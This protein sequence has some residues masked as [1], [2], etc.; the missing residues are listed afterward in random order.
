MRLLLM[1]L[2]AGLAAALPT[3]YD[4]A[5]NEVGTSEVFQQTRQEAS[6]SVQETSYFYSNEGESIIEITVAEAP[7]YN[8]VCMPS[9]ELVESAQVIVQETVDEEEA[10]VSAAAGSAAAS[11]A[12]SEGAAASAAAGESAAA[13]AAAAESAAASAAASEGAATSAAAGEAAAASAAAAESAAASA[14][15]A[16]DAAAAS[17]AASGG[18]AASAAAGEAAAA[19]AAAAESAAASAAAAE[20]AAASAAAGDAA[21]ASA[22]A[23]ESAAASAAAAEDAAASAAA[24]EGAATSAAAGGAA[25]ASAAAAESAAASAAAGEAAA[26]SAA[27]AESAAASAAAAEGAA[28]SAAAGESAAASAAAAEGAASS[29]AAGESAAAAAAAA[30]SA[31][32]AAAAAEGAAASAAAGEGAA[33]SSAAGEGA[34]ASAAAG[35]KTETSAAI[36]V[37]EYVGPDHLEACTCVPF[38]LCKDENIISDGAGQIDIRFGAGAGPS[39]TKCRHF[40]SVCCLHPELRPVPEIVA[41]LTA[42]P[43]YPS[44]GRRN[45]EGIGFAI[46]GFKDSESQF[47]EFPHMAIIMEEEYI[48]GE[49][50]HRYVC[51]GSLVTTNIILTAGH[52]VAGKDAS[53]LLVRLGDWNTK[54]L[55]E[56]L[57]HQEYRVTRSVVHER[58]NKRTLFNTVALLFLESEVELQPHIDTIC[59]PSL[60]DVS[61]GVPFYDSAHCVATG[62][63]RDQFEGGQYQNIM[64]QVDLSE[65][66][67]DDCQD[68]LRRTRLG[69][70]FRLH[71]SFTCAGGKPGVDTCRGDGGSPLICPLLSDPTKYVQV[72]IVA[73]G[74][75]CGQRGVPGVYAS[76]SQLLPWILEHMTVGGVS[77]V[78]ELVEE[79]EAVQVCITKNPFTEAEY[80]EQ[81]PI[82]VGPVPHD[83][84]HF[85][86]QQQGTGY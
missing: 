67:H 50:R 52:C 44:C 64:K 19:S 12:A 30:E 13:A 61:S 15:A 39:N 69:R 18:A 62:F 77:V 51:G 42:E 5:Q 53:K 76:V 43:Y 32:S 85:E 70:W 54:T 7:A 25:A 56:L 26:A 66:S 14:A 68:S 58:L 45:P 10:A 16:E 31:A 71:K 47:A 33:A 57:P 37:E 80:Q 60:A 75:G 73:W 84:E 22:A 81:I 23:A 24:A 82:K 3:A 2:C 40:E 83:V 8:L 72:G 46:E 35:G 1:A 21:A 29:A 28:S 34:A 27:A 63:G 20:G 41:E 78:E 36:Y 6:H 79:H 48:G 74:I 55:T 86:Q 49:L 38:Y 65:V 17:A 59:L 9:K 11:A 4:A